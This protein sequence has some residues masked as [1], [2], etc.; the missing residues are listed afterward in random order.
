MTNKLLIIG[1]DG[2]TLD[3]I[4]PWAKE[5]K[6]PVLAGLMQRGAYGRLKSVLPVLSS[7]AWTSFMTG[8]NPGKHGLFDFVKRAPNSYWLRP[9]NRSHIRSASLWKLLSS[10]GKRVVV[11]NVPMTYPPEQVNG[12]LITGLGTPAYKTFTYP[13]DLSQVLVDRGYQADLETALSPGKRSSFCN[14]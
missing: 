4:E 3:L 10:E 9:V 11:V 5:G 1:L 12:I 7:A 13:E 14:K 6:L 8:M 2:A